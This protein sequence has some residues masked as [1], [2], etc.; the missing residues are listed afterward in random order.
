[1]NW[2]YKKFYKVGD[3]LE[4]INN[5]KIQHFGIIEDCE[6]FWGSYILV[7]KK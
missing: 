7:Y 3:I 5:N 6:S 1:M 2:I 4:F